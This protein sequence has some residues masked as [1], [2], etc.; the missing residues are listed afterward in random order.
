MP[1]DP[2]IQRM[3]LT[4]ETTQLGDDCVN[5]KPARITAS[6]KDADIVRLSNGNAQGS[7]QSITIS[8]TPSESMNLLFD[9]APALQT[10]LKPGE[11]VDW[12][13]RP[14]ISASVGISFATNPDNCVGHDQDD[15]TIHC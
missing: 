2:K 12:K 9:P 8:L 11:S 4:T 7:G 3:T 14:T 13:I 1:N 10:T 5:R 6:R 15:V